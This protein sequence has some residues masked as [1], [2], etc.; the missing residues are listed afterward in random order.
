ML[1]RNFDIL[2]IPLLNIIVV[3]RENNTKIYIIITSSPFVSVISVI[4]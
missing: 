2:T 3:E 4:T 1:N